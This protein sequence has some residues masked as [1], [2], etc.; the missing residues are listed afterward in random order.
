MCICLLDD[1]KEH[2]RK[3]QSQKKEAIKRQSYIDSESALNLIARLLINFPFIENSTVLLLNHSRIMNLTLPTHELSKSRYRYIR[4][5][6]HR[7]S[8]ALS[9]LSLCTAHLRCATVCMTTA[10]G[11]LLSRQCFSTGKTAPVPPARFVERRTEWNPGSGTHTNVDV[12]CDMQQEG[13]Q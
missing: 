3:R 6:L 10:T 12:L 11:H 9:T 2:V 7:F 4:L 1:D 5:L 8:A 13:R